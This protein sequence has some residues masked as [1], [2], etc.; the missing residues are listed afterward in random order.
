MLDVPAFQMLL[1][2]S[3]GVAAMAMWLAMLFMFKPKAEIGLK[4]QAIVLKVT[5]ARILRIEQ[6][7]GEVI[8][9][10]DRD[11]AEIIEALAA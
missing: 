10:V 3:L 8:V 7:T 11:I 6:N 5:N 1:P 2:A 9:H 4:E